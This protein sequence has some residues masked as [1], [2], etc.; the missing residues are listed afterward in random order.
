MT[1]ID[2]VKQQ[3][4]GETSKIAWHELQYFFASGMAVYVS[5]ELDLIEVATCFINDNK[6]MVEKWMQEQLLM[7][8]PDQQAKE[9]YNND[10][11]VWAV[12]VKPWVL[13]QPIKDLQ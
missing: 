2:H 8:V 6:A 12:V 10:A 13:V 3:L 4:V 9:W 5:A 11:T 1:D 7:L